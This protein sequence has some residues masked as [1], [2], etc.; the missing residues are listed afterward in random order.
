VNFASALYLGI[1]HD[2]GSLRWNELTTGTPAALRRPPE[3]AEPETSFAA[4]V[5]CERAVAL[6]STLHAA[7]DLFGEACGPKTAVLYDD[8]VYPVLRWGMERAAGRR[9]PVVGFAHHSPE[10]LERALAALGP[11]LRPWVVADGFCPGCS[12]LAPLGEYARQALR[13]GGR[14]IVDDTQAIGIL[15]GGAPTAQLPYGA[16]GGGSLRRLALSGESV[17]VLASLAKAFGAPL[18]MVAG[19]GSFIDDFIDRSETFVHCSPPSLAHLAAASHALRRNASE[20]DRLRAVLAGRIR[21]FRRAM[22]ASGVRMRGGLFPFQRL[23]VNSADDGLRL[24]RALA[25][26][27]IQA[28]VEQVRCRP[29]VAL[30]FVITARHDEGQL[31]RAAAVLAMILRRSSIASIE[32]SSSLEV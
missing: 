25:G 9:I 32:T 18:A 23:L 7:W 13:Y 30:T 14:I 24:A 11:A 21:A 2:S 16:G 27:G 26:H 28:I 19:A 1:T 5:G 20:G 22:Q 29:Q 12:R 8:A 4:L 15:G 3:A 10:A 17:V 31:R 6:T